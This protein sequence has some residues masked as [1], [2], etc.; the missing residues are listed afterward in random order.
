M[1]IIEKRDHCHNHIHRPSGASTLN[2]I[3][4][5]IFKSLNEFHFISSNIESVIT[6]FVNK[7]SGIQRLTEWVMKNLALRKRSISEVEAV[8][9]MR[10][11][12][13]VLVGL[14]DSVSETSF[15][16]SVGNRFWGNY[17]QNNCEMCEKCQNVDFFASLWRTIAES[18]VCFQT[19]C[20]LFCEENGLFFECNHCFKKWAHY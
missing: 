6:F 11:N 7:E 20:Q 4:E 5:H 12:Q 18:L 2:S 16:G 14:L 17:V 1:E 3:V 19:V 10:N 15:A 8:L 13:R 9:T